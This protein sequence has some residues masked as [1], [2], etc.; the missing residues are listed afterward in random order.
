MRVVSRA[1]VL[2]EERKAAFSGVVAHLF[3]MH[4]RRRCDAGLSDHERGSEGKNES[5]YKSS[6]ML[7]QYFEIESLIHDAFLVSLLMLCY[8]MLS[9]LSILSIAKRNAVLMR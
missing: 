1:G 9:I 8:A 5:L 3:Y 4:P 2:Y 6:A 7:L